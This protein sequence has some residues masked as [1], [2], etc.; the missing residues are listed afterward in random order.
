V[1]CNLKKYFTFLFLLELFVVDAFV[2][3][4]LY[5]ITNFWLH[6]LLFLRKGPSTLNPPL[7]TP[8]PPRLVRTR[9]EM[10]LRVLWREAIPLCRLPSLSLRLKM[11]KR[12]GN[13][14]KT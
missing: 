10:K 11:Q 7:L 8:E 14:Q 4:I 2:L 9:T 6:A 5:R 13:A 1:T 3:R 12:S